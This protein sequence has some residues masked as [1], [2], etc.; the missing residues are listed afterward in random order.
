MIDDI[1]A[2]GADIVL[3]A[4]GVPAQ[5]LWLHRN[6][7]KLNANL[8]L[9]VGA[10]FDFLAGNVTRAPKMVRKAKMEWVWRL[11]MEPRRMARRYL[12][13]NVEFMAR[14]AIRAVT[15]DK[16]AALQ[17]RM[18]DLIVASA[19]TVLLAPLLLLTVLAIK[20]DSPRPGPVQA[21]AGWP[22]RHAFYH[23][24][25]PLDAH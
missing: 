20:I 21:G 18:L 7:D 10:L 4:L 22:R 17:Q 2:S 5:E 13:G 12:L 15:V 23:L 3:V 8:T 24:Q 14:A 9:G 25:V 19:A 1:N 6:A 16:G 11:A